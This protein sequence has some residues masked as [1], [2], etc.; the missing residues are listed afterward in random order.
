MKGAIYIRIEVVDVSCHA[1]E[2]VI[3]VGTRS[4][5]IKELICLQ[6]EEKHKTKYLYINIRKIKKE[7]LKKR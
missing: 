3:P 6:G 2:Y 7:K 1:L 5:M 4:L